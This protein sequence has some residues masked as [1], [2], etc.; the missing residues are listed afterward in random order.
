MDCERSFLG[1]NGIVWYGSW[2]DRWAVDLYVG[3]GACS[4]TNDQALQDFR[5]RYE[6]TYVYLELHAEQRE[7]I[8][9]VRA[10][11]SSPNK[12]G[13]LHL[14]TEEYG[15]LQLN[16]GSEGHTL[17][18]K[19]PPV[20]VFQNGNWAH[21]FY[22]RP[23]R[24]YRRGLCQDNSYILSTS[25]LLGGGSS[26]FNLKALK[27]AFEHKTY[28]A[29]E[30][31]KLLQS[32]PMKSVALADN[33]SLVISPFEDKELHVIMHYMQPI[34]EFKPQKG[35]VTLHNKIYADLLRK[36]FSS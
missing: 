36:H 15:V 25:R 19:Y 27:N 17:K 2:C 8:A 28:D 30:A 24:Q 14:D 12:V 7:V 31:V 33:L 10:V 3:C 21:V 22:R 16:L 1:C 26:G 34:A 6:G 5:R 32:S 23:Q 9:Y 4:M 13:W 35:I 20:G 29:L 18:F 11:E